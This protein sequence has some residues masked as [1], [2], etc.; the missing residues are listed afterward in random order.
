MAKLYASEGHQLNIQQ[1]KHCKDVA[2]SSKDEPC[3]YSVNLIHCF[4]GK[5]SFNMPPSG[6]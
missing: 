1:V 2:E 5:L 3:N 6:K 4:V